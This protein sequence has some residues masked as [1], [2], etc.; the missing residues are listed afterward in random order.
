MIR[1]A[2]LFLFAIYFAVAD[3]Y[4]LN[5]VA[6]FSVQQVDIGD[7]FL[8]GFVNGHQYVDMGL[9]SG[10][11]WAATNV[12]ATERC[13]RGD[14]FAW[15]EVE[16]KISFLKDNWKYNFLSEEKGKRKAGTSFALVIEPDYDAASAQWGEE[17]EMPSKQQ[18]DE[19]LHVCKHYTTEIDGVMGMLFESINGNT[20]FFPYHGGRYYT[21][22]L[23]EGTMGYFWTS[24]NVIMYGKTEQTFYA[25]ADL[26]EHEQTA[27]G[28][29]GM[30][31]RPVLSRNKSFY[32]HQLNKEDVTT[33]LY[34]DRYQKYVDLGLPSKTLW[35]TSNLNA[36]DPSEV[37]G[38]YAW[39]G[40]DNVMELSKYKIPYL[41]KKAA[42]NESSG[43][44]SFTKYVSSKM[45]GKTDFKD[46]LDQEDDAA[47][48]LLGNEW[49]IPTPEQWEELFKE[50]V[51]TPFIYLGNEGL[52]FKGKNDAVLFIPNV[53]Y[54]LY[55][56]SYGYKQ[57]SSHFKPFYYHTNQ[58]TLSIYS[59]AMELNIVTAKG[60]TC[61]MNRGC[62]MCIRPVKIN[63]NKVEGEKITISG[64]LTTKT[65]SG[66]GYYEQS[67]K[68]TL[69]CSQLMAK[70]EL[71]DKNSKVLNT[72]YFKKGSRKTSFKFKP[73]IKKI[74]IT[75]IKGTTV[76]QTI[77]VH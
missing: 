76:Y 18:F 38:L 1:Q 27:P 65:Y 14:F 32:Q 29:Y 55:S 50:C 39:G 59:N 63:K 9:P 61:R 22:F 44:D 43:K 4:G 54:I 56:D 48:C 72:K 21:H 67:K 75:T 20:L 34:E 37:G 41:H 26:I 68:Y 46:V 25:F 10:T 7:E 53:P 15:G 66:S 6:A 16:P 69:E 52:L 5:S 30:S 31:V 11:L 47:S 33:F 64:Y 60:H 40:R 8:E 51:V 62:A 57:K 74:R 70:Y 58:Q 45:Y 77:T 24:N 23:H 28:F 35:A 2:F 19:L 73:E 42:S 17:W 3:L 49:C 71:L 12:G 36:E 13:D